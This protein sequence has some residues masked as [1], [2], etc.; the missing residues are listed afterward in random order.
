MFLYFG[1]DLSFNVRKTLTS[2]PRHSL[3][4]LNG[5][6]LTKNYVLNALEIVLFDF[7]K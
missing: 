6:F 2:A 1:F 5:K 4:T 3:S 7:L